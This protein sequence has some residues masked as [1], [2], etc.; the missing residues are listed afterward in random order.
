MEFR[1]CSSEKSCGSDDEHGPNSDQWNEFGGSASLSGGAVLPGHPAGHG[2]ASVKELL[3]QSSTKAPR[4]GSF[5]QQCEPR[6]GYG[7]SEAAS[8]VGNARS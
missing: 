8:G 1:K 2:G 7:R 4:R 3:D 6:D 5:I